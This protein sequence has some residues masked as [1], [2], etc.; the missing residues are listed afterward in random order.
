MFINP[1]FYDL[2]EWDQEEAKETDD[3]IDYT[4]DWITDLTY[5]GENINSEKNQKIIHEAYFSDAEEKLKEADELFE[6]ANKEGVYSDRFN[7][8]TVV[9]AAILFLLGIVEIFKGIKKR[10]IIIILSG[11][12]FVITTGYLVLIPFM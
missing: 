8:V 12:V 11:L 1:I 7:M 10:Y 9:Y 4:E 3:L 5:S 6:L 2:K